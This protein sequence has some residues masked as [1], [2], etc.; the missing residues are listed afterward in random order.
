MSSKTAR[1]SGEASACWIGWTM[2]AGSSI[3]LAAS[4]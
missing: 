3:G 1:T 2:G 4:S